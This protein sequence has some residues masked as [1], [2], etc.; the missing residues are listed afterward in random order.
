MESLKSARRQM[1]LLLVLCA[2]IYTSANRSM[3]VH[4]HLWKSRELSFTLWLLKGPERMNLVDWV[5]TAYLQRMAYLAN[6]DSTRANRTREYEF[7]TPFGSAMIL[8]PTFGRDTLGHTFYSLFVSTDSVVY[9]GAAPRTLQPGRHDDGFIEDWYPDS[10]ETETELRALCREYG[11]AIDSNA[12]T[13]YADLKRTIEH[14]SAGIPQLPSFSMPLRQ[15]SYFLSALFLFVYLNVLTRLKRG[16][17]HLGDVSDVSWVVIDASDWMEKVL[18]FTWTIVFAI[19]PPLV[20]YSLFLVC[21]DASGWAWIQ[22]LWRLPG[23]VFSGA[24]IVLYIMLAVGLTLGTTY[25]NYIVKLR[26][27]YFNSDPRCPR[28]W[29]RTKE[30]RARRIKP[31]INIERAGR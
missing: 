27:S 13:T 4:E 23:C 14:L 31:H 5:D 20:M 6:S 18:A 2:L 3:S 25:C 30:V 1:V 21:I 15:A 7:R 17:R 8:Y 19:L 11:V 26:K 16:R 28:P 22:G 10:L 24:M 29:L 12:F 9:Q